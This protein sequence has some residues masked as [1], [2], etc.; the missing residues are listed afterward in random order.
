L[1]SKTTYTISGVIEFIPYDKY[2]QKNYQEKI[3][4]HLVLLY[5]DQNNIKYWK[6]EGEMN[7]IALPEYLI[8]NEYT[9]KEAQTKFPEV[10]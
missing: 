3:S 6:P 8:N 5:K 4:E 2:Y 9:L 1:K 10:F 7:H